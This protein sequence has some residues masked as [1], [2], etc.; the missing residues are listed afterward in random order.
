M[1]FYCVVNHDRTF[2]HTVG[3]VPLRQPTQPI[4]LGGHL[5]NDDGS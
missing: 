5:E 1:I 3:A 4:M 2:D